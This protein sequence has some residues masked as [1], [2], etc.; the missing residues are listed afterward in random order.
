[1]PEMLFKVVCYQINF[2]LK[3]ILLKLAKCFTAHCFITTVMNASTKTSVKASTHARQV[4][5]C[6]QMT[7]ELGVNSIWCHGVSLKC[8]LFSIVIQLSKHLRHRLLDR[9]N[10][11]HHWQQHLCRHGDL[12]GSFHIEKV[13]LD[14]SLHHGVYL[15]ALQ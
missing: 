9:K 12:S 15:T 13:I 10:L 7:N 5:S 6:I 14:H 2:I 1:M 11:H 3:A 4:V 8:R